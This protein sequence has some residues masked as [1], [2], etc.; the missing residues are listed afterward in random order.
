[1]RQGSRR[2]DAETVR[3][4]T[5]VSKTLDRCSEETLDFDIQIE[6][7]TIQQV[8]KSRAYGS[9]ANAADT[10]EKYPHVAP[11]DEIRAFAS[12]DYNYAITVDYGD[13]PGLISKILSTL[14]RRSSLLVTQNAFMPRNSFSLKTSCPSVRG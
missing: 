10:S 1:M 6:K 5:A 8:G 7:P 14:N 13:T 3:R 2:C 4:R 11:P 12:C 9:L